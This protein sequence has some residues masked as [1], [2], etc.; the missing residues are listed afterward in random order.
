MIN[1]TSIMEVAG[2]HSTAIH[3]E[4][5]QKAR[6]LNIEGSQVIDVWAFSKDDVS[7]LL[8][9]E[10]TRSCLEKLIPNVGDVLYSNLRRPIIRLVEDSSPG[11]HDLLLSACDEGRYRLLGHVGYHR[12]CADNL[13]QS[14]HSLGYEISDIPSPFNLFEN[15]H[16]GEKGELSIEPPLVKAGESVTLQAEFDIIL[17]MSSCPMDLAL[18]NGPDMRS[19]PFSVEKIV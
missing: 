9:T 6:I 1:D 18:T 13:R 16:I 5:G 7:E 11:I 10:H 15:V 3:L 4:K 19:K 2:G 17:V 8:S 14:M 12:N